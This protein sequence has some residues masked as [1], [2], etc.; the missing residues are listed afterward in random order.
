MPP[1]KGSRYNTKQKRMIAETGKKPCAQ[2]QEIKPVSE[3][4]V[5]KARS[6]G[7]DS[8]CKPCKLGR[9]DRVRH[10]ANARRNKFVV[11]YGITLDQRNTMASEQENRC[12]ICRNVD[13][14]LHVDHCHKSGKIRQL[15]CF[16]CNT[17]LGNAGDD[18]EILKSAIAYLERHST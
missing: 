3:F 7:Y 16:K 1:T 15:I 6:S 11:R 4:H 13:D 9:I 10:N 5:S 12:A 8:Y 18:I 17:L 2:C 14:R